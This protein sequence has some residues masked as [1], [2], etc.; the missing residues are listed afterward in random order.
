MPGGCLLFQMPMETRFTDSATCVVAC[1][2]AAL[3]QSLHR[4]GAVMALLHSALRWPT[5]ASECERAAFA[6]LLVSFRPMHPFRFVLVL[7]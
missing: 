6:E 2:G 5:A 1:S 7:V 3:R 4:A